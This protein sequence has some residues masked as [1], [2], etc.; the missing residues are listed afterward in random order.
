M[1]FKNRDLREQGKKVNR[2]ENPTL[3]HK[4]CRDIKKYSK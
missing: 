1:I 2:S 4:V 3:Y